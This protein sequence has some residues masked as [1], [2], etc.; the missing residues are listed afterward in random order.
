MERLFPNH[1]LHETR[2]SFATYARKSGMDLV[3]TKRIMGHTVRDITEGTYTHLDVN[4][5][6][7]EMAK[8]R[9]E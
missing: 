1:I 6:K 4:V 3:A 2:H 7:E 8:Y 9:I 5:L